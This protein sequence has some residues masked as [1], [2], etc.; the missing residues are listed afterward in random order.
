[1]RVHLDKIASV[2]RNLKLQR[3]VTTT[4][5]VEAASGTVVVGRVRGEKSVYNHLEDVHGR[6][7]M[8]HEGDVIAGALGHRNALHGYE[9]LVPE[10]V[11]PGD[12]LNILN[13]GGVI[14]RCISQNPEVGPPFEIEILGQA[15]AFPEFQSRQHKP[16]NITLG[17]LTGRDVASIPPVVFVLGTC[18]NAGKTAAASVIV[19]ALSQ[20]G[21]RVGGAK[22]TGVS[23]MR[24]ILS[25]SDYGA[26]YALDFTDA[27]VVSTG[28]DTAP[29]V[30]HVLLSELAAKGAD[31]IVA[32]TGDG[33][34]G[35]YGVQ[36]LLADPF[37]RGHSR[38]FVLCAN[39]PVGVAGGVACL[40]E[41]YD[42]MVDV[43]AGPATD[44][45]VGVRFVEREFG[46]S[47]INALT[48]SKALGAAI[49]ERICP[50][51]PGRAR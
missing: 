11:R 23:L 44:N 25:M 45:R 10:S 13:L 7:S 8:L 50:I 3:A 15:L 18:M 22:L 4:D 2:T 39:D 46:L 34:M 26:D 41:Q 5:T 49:L 17:A 32:E 9:G 24:D 30:A 19:R 6:M 42:I 38:A 36:A 31:V 29:R 20:T 37:L 40:R 43:V 1:V 27:G 12:V 16:S 14:G 35:E 47:A 33:I 21:L 51:A 48:N 28:P